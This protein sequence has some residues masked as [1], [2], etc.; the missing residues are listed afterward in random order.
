M[1]RGGIDISLGLSVRTPCSPSVYP[2][3]WRSNW[4][5]T[6]QRARRGTLDHVSE[7][8]ESR[9]VAGAV[10]ASLRAVPGDD[11][12][13]VGAPGAPRVDDPVIVTV[14]RGL[15][16]ARADHAALAGRY[17]VERFPAGNPVG[18]EAKPGMRVVRCELWDGRHRVKPL[19]TE[20]PGKA[21]I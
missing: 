2:E 19:G 6:R 12:A 20:E 16:E 1:P 18:H 17:P 21:V 9:P 15:A 10:P 7:R 14:D 5:A 13:Q 3:A 8:P 4:V 11:A